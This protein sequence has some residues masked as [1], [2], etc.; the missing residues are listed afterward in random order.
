[1][2]NHEPQTPERD[3][4]YQRRMDRWLFNEIHTELKYPFNL[5]MWL[6]FLITAHLFCA[7]VFAWVILFNFLCLHVIMIRM[8][9][10]L[11]GRAVV[12]FISIHWYISCCPMSTPI[13]ADLSSHFRI[14][15]CVPVLTDYLTCVPAYSGSHWLSNMC[16]GVSRPSLTI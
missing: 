10:Y 16:P 9:R 15:N 14:T 8:S 2:T 5:S 1:M 7:L 6:F 13:K 11:W 12:L 4:Q 3:K